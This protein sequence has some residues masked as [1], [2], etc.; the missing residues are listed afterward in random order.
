VLHRFIR[1]RRLAGAAAGSAAVLLAVPGS[2]QAAYGPPPPGGGGNPG[3]FGCVVASLTV[4]PNGTILG[5][6][7][8]TGLTALIRIRPGTFGGLAQIT[9]TQP[10]GQDGKCGPGATLSVRGQASYRQVG[11]IGVLIQRVGSNHLIRPRQPMV[12]TLISFAITPATLIGHFAGAHFVRD[13]AARAGWGT[14]RVV[15]TGSTALVVVNR[16]GPGSHRAG[17][18]AR[19]LDEL[20]WPFGRTG[21]AVLLSTLAGPAPRG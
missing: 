5:P 9:I 18:T 13:P 6:L 21:P 17:L 10:P 3:Q 1:L 16:T 14:A 4:G 7:R 20:P 2:A 19:W 8:L 11:G 15:L 12:L